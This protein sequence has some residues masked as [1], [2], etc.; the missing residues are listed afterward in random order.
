M[1]T[2]TIMLLVITLVRVAN[3]QDIITKTLTVLKL[4]LLVLEIL[5]IK[6]IFDYAD[7]EPFEILR[8]SPIF[9]Y[10]DDQP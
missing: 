9:D 10:A 8:I 1:K 4:M 3:A 6:L 7:G 2:I 5:N